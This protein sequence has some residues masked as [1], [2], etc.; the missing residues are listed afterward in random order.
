MHPHRHTATSATPA[1]AQREQQNEIMQLWRQNAKLKGA[2]VAEYC[3]DL[4]EGE[5][6]PKFLLFGEGR[7]RG[8]WRVG[9]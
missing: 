5:D 2:A 9:L 4:L 7:V 6:P 1:G 8:G 3:E